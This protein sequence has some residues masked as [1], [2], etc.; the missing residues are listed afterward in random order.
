MTDHRI[1]QPTQ[2][3]RVRA[4]VAARR[5]QRKRDGST[6]AEAAV[7]MMEIKTK[8]MVAVVAALWQR[9]DNR[10]GYTVAAASL[11]QQQWQQWQLG[12]GGS[13]SSLA[14]VAMAAAWRWQQHGNGGGGS[15][16]VAAAAG[17]Q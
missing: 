10:G 5:R 14:A 16:E 15:A 7:T 13:G 11:A 6:V 12:G 2:K 8:A 3:R 4:L 1:D 17:Q 9:G